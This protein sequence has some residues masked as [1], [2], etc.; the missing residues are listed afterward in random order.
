MTSPARRQ[1][2]TELSVQLLADHANSYAVM[3]KMKLV[4]FV[5]DDVT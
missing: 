1:E 2:L 5:R 4:P 3:R